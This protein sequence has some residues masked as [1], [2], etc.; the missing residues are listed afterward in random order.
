MKLSFYLITDSISI[1]IEVVNCYKHIQPIPA[2]LMGT[3]VHQTINQYLEDR[4]SVIEAGIHSLLD[5][6]YWFKESTLEE[7]YKGSGIH[8][9]ATHDLSTVNSYI[10]ALN[11]YTQTSTIKSLYPEL[12]I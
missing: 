3:S 5:P 1:N 8:Y 7:Y 10:N 11:Y 9:L 2:I 12:F 6:S 4:D